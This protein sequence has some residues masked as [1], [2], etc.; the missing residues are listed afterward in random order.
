MPKLI[1]APSFCYNLREHWLI[2][3]QI[4]PNDEGTPDASQTFPLHCTVQQSRAQSEERSAFC[5]L[6]LP[7]CLQIP[8]KRCPQLGVGEGRAYCCVEV[9]QEIEKNPVGIPPA[10]LNQQLRQGGAGETEQTVCPISCLKCLKPAFQLMRQ[11]LEVEAVGS[12]TSEMT[13]KLKC[14]MKS[15]KAF[16]LHSNSSH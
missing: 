15:S 1:M 14:I 5:V 4:G 8:G 2:T 16:G 9:A 7:A 11:G 12:C 13:K 6:R 3:I 10:H